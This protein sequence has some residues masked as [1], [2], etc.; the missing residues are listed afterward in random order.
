MSAD[1]TFLKKKRKKR[2]YNKTT[3]FISPFLRR[4]ACWET[5]MWFWK[6][7]NISGICAVEDT[8][9]RIQRLQRRTDKVAE[10]VV[11]PADPDV[12]AFD[13]YWTFDGRTPS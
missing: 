2:K 10:N 9:L 13:P 3:T 6:S 5:M 8:R 12:P 7:S 4:D 1:Q 11:S